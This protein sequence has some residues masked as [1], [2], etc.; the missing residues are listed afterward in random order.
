MVMREAQDLSPTLSLDKER[1]S[2]ESAPGARKLR[3][4]L[5]LSKRAS[6]NCD[7]PFRP[8]LLVQ[9][10]GWGEVRWSV[11]AIRRKWLRHS[12]S[13]TS[14]SR[15][16]RCSQRSLLDQGEVRRCRAYGSLRGFLVQGPRRRGASVGERSTAKGPS[17]Y[18]LPR[19][20]AGEGM[21]GKRTVDANVSKKSSERSGTGQ[22]ELHW[23]TE[24]SSRSRKAVSGPLPY[25]L[26]GQGAGVRR[27]NDTSVGE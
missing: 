1:E 15:R 23:A 4:D 7:D 27:S 12:D 18:P 22:S 16:A 8:P 17:P 10:E 26:L 2:D 9:G 13:Q 14:L 21:K 24:T 11:C 5:L 6:P 20:I 3:R 25:P 19:T